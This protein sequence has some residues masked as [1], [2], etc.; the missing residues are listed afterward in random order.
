MRLHDYPPSGN[1]YKVRL[2]C[3]HLGIGYER[4]PYDIAAGETRTAEFRAARTC[5]PT[6]SS[7]RR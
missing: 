1:C 5:P 7:S 2:L 6:G 3:A 4:V